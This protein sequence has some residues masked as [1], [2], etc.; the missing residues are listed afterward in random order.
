MGLDRAHAVVGAVG[1]TFD[2]EKGI[3]PGEIA[4]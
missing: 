4:Q 1:Q 3:S 2:L